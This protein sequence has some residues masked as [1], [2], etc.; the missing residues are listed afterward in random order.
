LRFLYRPGLGAI[1]VVTFVMN[2]MNCLVWARF[3]FSA[4]KPWGRLAGMWK[5]PH[6]FPCFGVPFIMVDTLG[7]LF[8]RLSCV[9][10]FLFARMDTGKSK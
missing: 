4:G 8:L 3:A 7:I 2:S 1:T 5:S 6:L 10:R 9:H